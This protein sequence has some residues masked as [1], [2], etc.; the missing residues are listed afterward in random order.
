MRFSWYVIHRASSKIPSCP[1]CSG[2]VT[3][4]SRLGSPAPFLLER[5]GSLLLFGA[6]GRCHAL[7]YRGKGLILEYLVYSH[8]TAPGFA[9]LPCECW[10][11]VIFGRYLFWPLVIKCDQ[12]FVFMDV[13]ESI[14]VL[15]R[16]PPRMHA[17][18]A[19]ILV[20]YLGARRKE[21]GGRES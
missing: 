6:R 14:H 18:T 9:F 4:S 21:A 12:T 19:A 16:T 8:R 5:A 10:V 2:W 17:R 13:C 20:C 1:L 15:A 11:V 7:E 3:F